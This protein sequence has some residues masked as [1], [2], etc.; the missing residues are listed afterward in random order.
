MDRNTQSRRTGPWPAGRRG[1]AAL[2][3]AALATTLAACSAAGAAVDPDGTGTQA[4]PALPQ[5]QKSAVPAETRLPSMGVL[6]DGG[7]HWCSAS[8]VDS[9]KGN[10]VV[11]AAHCVFDDEGAPM[12]D[13]SFAPGFHGKDKGTAPEGTWKVR[14]VQV[15]GAWPPPD[16]SD[17]SSDQDDSDAAQTAADS[18]D[19]AFLT[20]DPDAKGRQVQQVV[21]AEVPDWNSKAERRVTVFG[22]PNAEHNPDN[23]P[24]ACTTD[25]TKD[26]D[27]DGSMLMECGGFFD[28]TSGGPWL[29]DYRDAG[30]RGRI[31]GVTSGGDT[32]AET[33]AV[34]FD[35]A[36]KALYEKAARA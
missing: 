21:G 16:D 23:H 31:I 36:A 24:I 6:L 9:P 19:F 15:G 8:V 35:D 32:D 28:G 25:T 22:Y 3:C 1:A 30:H 4:R 26:P 29:A 34:V 20:L 2:W 13:F 33:T 17:D 11:T 7:G 12:K 27:L 18:T 5:P 14:A 10:V